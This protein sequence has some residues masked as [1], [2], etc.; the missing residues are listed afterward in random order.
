MSG[1]L[2]VDNTGP[3]GKIAVE[4]IT[5]DS[6][7]ELKDGIYKVW[8][9]QYYARSSKGFTVEIEFNNK[10]FTFEHNKAIRTG[11]NVQ[12]AEVTVKD[13]NFSIKGNFK[14][15]S[16]T[17][18]IWGINTQQFIEVN[19]VMLSP[20]YWGYNKGNKHYFFFI[21]D[22]I[23]DDAKGF[24]NEFLRTDLREHRKVFEALSDK[25]KV[26]FS[27]NQLS[28]LGFS[29]TL[30]NHLTVKVDGKTLK[31]NFSTAKKLAKS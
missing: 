14:S 1:Q 12:V 25:M 29:S 17:K 10:T 30:K 19:T 7:S 5:F 16:T 13:G 18:E 27:D 6:L 22:C 28:G 4:N 26:P 20:N 23:N 21:K 15:E 31:V 3:S 9:N 24:Y 11:N 8:V 2:D